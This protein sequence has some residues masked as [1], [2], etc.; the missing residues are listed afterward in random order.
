MYVTAHAFPGRLVVKTPRVSCVHVSVVFIL[1]T[2]TRSETIATLMASSVSVRSF[3][4][5]TRE[6]LLLRDMDSIYNSEKVNLGC[7]ASYEDVN[8]SLSLLNM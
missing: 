7:D 6:H 1:P 2:L 8:T 4:R 5:T 3:S